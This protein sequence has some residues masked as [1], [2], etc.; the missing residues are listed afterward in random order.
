MATARAPA[1]RRGP[2]GPVSPAAAVL[3]PPDQ[4]AALRQALEYWMIDPGLR[5][6]LKAGAQRAGARLPQWSDTVARIDA[7]LEAAR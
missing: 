4:P 2:G 7:S 1:L 6:R 5:A 3:V